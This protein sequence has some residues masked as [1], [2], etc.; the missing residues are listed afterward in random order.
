MRIH[1]QRK[2]EVVVR[3]RVGRSVG[4]RGDGELER[5]DEAIGGGGGRRQ[6]VSRG[7]R[8]CSS[9]RRCRRMAHFFT[10]TDAVTEWSGR[11]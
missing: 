2:I 7:G 8:R 5:A 11:S 4:S 3:E 1:E 10:S 9:Y 6:R